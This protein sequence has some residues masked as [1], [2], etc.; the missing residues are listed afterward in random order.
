MHGLIATKTHQND[1]QPNK[2]DRCQFFKKGHTS[3]FPRVLF[4]NIEYRLNYLFNILI[5]ISQ[6]KLFNN[7]L[8][9]NYTI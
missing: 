4:Y 2:R 3:N 5:I 9:Y 7:F 8:L 1:N 6:N